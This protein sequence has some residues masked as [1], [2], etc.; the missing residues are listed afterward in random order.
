[1]VKAAENFVYGDKFFKEGDEIPDSLVP[2]LEKHQNHVLSTFVNVDGTWHKIDDPKIKG[3]VEQRKNIEKR[4]IKHFIEEST[5]T[6]AYAE[7][8]I[9][10]K[11]FLE[12]QSKK[13]KFGEF[14][15]WA[16]NNYNVTGRGVNEIIN[17]ILAEKKE[18]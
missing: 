8:P 14:R 10:K 13:M 3:W 6:S 5:V 16:K 15:E 18:L 4:I 2:E 7:S 9:P 1:M 11:E 12:E 17:D